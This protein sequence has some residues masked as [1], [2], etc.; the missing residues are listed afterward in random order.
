MKNTTQTKTTVN[1]KLHVCAG[2][3]ETGGVGAK[4]LLYVEGQPQPKL[5][6]KPC[7]EVL[8]KSAPEGVKA[9]L[10]PSRQLRDEWQSKRMANNFWSAAFQSAKLLKPAITASKPV[11]MTVTTPP[12]M[13]PTL[14]AT[15]TEIAQ[16]A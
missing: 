7:G 12:P 5:V 9:R 15:P 6:H 10:V 4:W 8:V 11:I 14:A 16:A 3:N 13:T 1:P 2:C